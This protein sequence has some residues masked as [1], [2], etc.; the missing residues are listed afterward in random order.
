MT[1]SFRAHLITITILV[2]IIGMSIYS[3]FYTAM[4]LTGFLV[5]FLL[6]WVYMMLVSLLSGEW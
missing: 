5:L 3:P 1:N 4:F 2:F 6:F